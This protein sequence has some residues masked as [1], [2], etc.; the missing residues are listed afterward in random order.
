[1]NIERGVTVASALR[2]EI[3]AQRQHCRLAA[4]RLMLPKVFLVCLTF[5]LAVQKASAF[6]APD[7]TTI[8]TGYT[9]A[10]YLGGSTSG[11][12]RENQAN[13]NQTYFWQFA[14]EIEC[15]VDAYE[16]TT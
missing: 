11:S 3:G 16:W 1:M 6:T 5:L 12:F 2:A 8:V 10:F 4:W 7:A 13:A 15:V 9:N 14:N